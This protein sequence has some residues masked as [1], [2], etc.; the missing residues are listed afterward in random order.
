[1]KFSVSKENHR[2]KP[3]LF[4]AFISLMS[5]GNILAQNATIKGMVIDENGSS[6]VGVYV[7]YGDYKKGTSTRSD[8]SYTLSIPA[9][10][11]VEIHF[12]FLGYDTVVWTLNPMNRAEYSRDIKMR[13]RSLI[14]DQVV[15]EGKQK[16]ELGLER[17][18][19]KVASQVS[20]PNASLE[21]TLIFQGLGVTSTNELSSS[22]NV[23]GGNFDENLI[24]ING[25]EVYRPFLVRS[26][27][28]EGLS[29]VNPELVSRVYFS[30][31]GFSSRYGDKMSSV[32][33]IEY[34][35]PEKKFGG[36]VE[37]SLLG[38]QVAVEQTSDDRRFT[39]IHGLR[40]RTNRYVLN[41]LD[42][43]GEYTP[44][45]VDY[46]G[47][48]TYDISD[49]IEL[50]VLASLSQNSYR[51]VPENRTTEFGTFNESL[52][53]NI[54]YDGQEINRYRTA[55]GA[56]QLT[57]R[58]SKD[59]KLRFT[60]SGYASREEETL[61]VTG[62]YRLGEL[63]KDVGS[64]SFGEVISLRGAGGFIDHA[65][66]FY[67]ISN[68]GL[69][70]DGS[71]FKKNSTLSWGA[72]F[73]YEQVDDI[74]SEWEYQDSA[75]FNIPQS[76]SDKIVLFESFRNSNSLDW[77][78]MMAFLQYER[79][80]EIDSHLVSFNIGGRINYFD[81]NGE[82]VGGPRVAVLFKPHWKKNMTFRAAWGYYHQPPT[83][84]E[85]RNFN[86]DLN[87]DIKSQTA[88]HYVLGYDYLFTM[89]KRPFQFTTEAYYKDLRNLIPYELDNVRIRYYA[90]NNSNGYAT[91]I[92][93]K[94][95]G[96]FVKG[97]E[98]WF[99]MSFMSTRE[100][101]T[102]DFFYNYFD[103]NGDRTVPGDPF[104]PVVDSSIVFP[105]FIPRPTEQLFSF[106][107]FFQDYIPGNPTYKVN[108]LLYLASGLPT[109]PPSYNRYEDILRMPWY[110]RVDIGFT[111]DFLIDKNL[112]RSKLG[113]SKAFSKFKSFGV[114]VEVFNLLDI[115][116]TISYRWLRDFNGN[117][118]GIPN[119]LTLRQLNIK[120][121]ARF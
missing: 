96:E 118:Y 71:L 94:L 75:G 114:A 74:Y 33:D 25:I 77:V 117:Y 22:Y 89:W 61:D 59:L 92:D 8:G 55:L 62:A 67:T 90:T 6:M 15:I 88:I 105:G 68:I 102:D 98:S 95:N 104:N 20:S 50:G 52:Q 73:Y 7:S 26:G 106:A 116:N 9:G 103:E 82:L 112:N 97:V 78:R 56:L 42:T 84:R 83:Y 36:F 43:R 113:R 49:R 48:F 81:Y 37:L 32:L 120:I 19:P 41:T 4:T 29:I 69:T 1:M 10:E 39:Q 14:F 46:Q 3:F 65:R 2:L 66:N 51:L 34:K 57:V 70:H 108:I 107:A 31:G 54:F 111:K 64:E 121:Q 5:L 58:P 100:D 27:R 17:I 38:A 16:T 45:F 101:L 24:Y 53:L 28:Q 60:G 35:Q 18:E 87:P 93:F 44:N 86:G 91:G 63:D 40:Y 13:Q 99:S 47:Y 76:P 80:F 119:Y 72:R 115:R 21:R 30:S 23:R 11:E 110:R 109:G 79:S 12:I 85:M